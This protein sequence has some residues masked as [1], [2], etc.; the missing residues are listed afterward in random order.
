MPLSTIQAEVL[1]LIAANRL[2]VLKQRWLEAAARARKLVTDLPPAEI[3]CL[4]LD[5]DQQ[6]AT[7]DP[8]SDAFPQL[9]RHRG[10]LRGAWPTVSHY[11]GK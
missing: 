4:Y 10:S 5:A 3:G 9:A 11:R 6:P 2:G 8:S 7:P 1:R